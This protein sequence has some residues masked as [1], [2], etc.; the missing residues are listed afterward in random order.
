MTETS[1]ADAAAALFSA[2]V[3]DDP[4]P[5]FRR[6]RSECPVARTDLAGNAV[7]LV[8][9]NDDV[10]WALRHPEYFTSAGNHLGL[11]EQPL[12]PL[13]V[14][15]PQHTKYRRLLNP[16]FVPREIEK[17]EPEVRR[18]V[19]ELI[20]GFA[21]RGTCDFHEELAT[22][23]PCGIFLAL[24][25]LPTEDLP[26][27]LQWRD[28]TIRPAVEPGDFEGAQRIRAK[29]AGEISDYFRGVIARCR[30][31]P[32]ESLLS[33]IVHSTIDGR[34]LSETELLGTCHLLLL[35]GLD[36][37]TATLD[38]MVEFLATHPDHRRQIV[39]D[40]SLIPGAVEELLRWLSPVMVVPRSM[41]QDL[42]MQ[43]VELKAGDA[44][45]LV[46]GAANDDETEFGEPEVD[47][48]RQPNR[49]VAFGG[50]NH[51]CL[52]AHLARLE[53]RVAIE[54]LHRRIPDYRIP[55]GV[56]IHF[57]PGIRQADRLPLE[58][59]PA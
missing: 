19:G 26:R 15:P 57:S 33:R 40:R 24:A 28:D 35:G 32:D 38:C 2:A 22:P 49:H 21:G 51:L 56:E 4:H 36:T 10:W 7:V 20:D 12:I 47:F 11:A 18:I 58:F 17:L 39:E 59:D 48:G 41:K 25:G 43:G 50:G 6:L 53:L 1:G 54:E 46:I 9:R 37:V 29:T 5:T 3:A 23:L 31:D 16:Q 14:D 27:F 13:E 30:R 44:V 52:G 45:T 55:E 8:T 42:E 34:P